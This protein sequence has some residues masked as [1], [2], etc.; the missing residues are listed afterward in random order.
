MRRLCN[1]EECVWIIVVK[2][3]SKMNDRNSRPN[4]SVEKTLGL[5]EF[6]ARSERPLPL[7]EIATNVNIPE[8]TTMRLLKTLHANGY[9]NQDPSSLRYSLSLKF[10]WIGGLVRSH[11]SVS[12]L[13]EKLLME[14][15]RRCDESTN[16]AVVQGNQIVYIAVFDL[17][18]VGLQA[19][20]EIGTRCPMY[21]DAIGKLFLAEYEE[22]QLNEYLKK[23]PLDS[24]TIHTISSRVNLVRE[25]KRIATEGYSVDNEEREIGVR[26]IAAPIRDYTGKII[27]GISVSGPSM[28]ITKDSVELLKDIVRDTALKISRR[29]AYQG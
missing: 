18:G 28:R 24:Y 6:L 19:T 1:E 7:K 23:T 15:S 12:G 4:Q 2:R 25:L 8:S 11:I 20:K 3:G 5:I 9:V 21:C 27:A 14:M 10:T 29:F 16:I 17:P 13:S 22:S 26:S